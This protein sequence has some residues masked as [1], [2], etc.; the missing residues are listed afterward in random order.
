MYI[1][2]GS[3]FDRIEIKVWSDPEPDNRVWETKQSLP[4]MANFFS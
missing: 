3:K 1:A 4:G 2:I